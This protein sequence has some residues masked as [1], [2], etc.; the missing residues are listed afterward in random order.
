MLGNAA[1]KGIQKW[2]P[3]REKWY[4]KGTALGGWLCGTQ[5]GASDAE[6]K[7]GKQRNSKEPG[8]TQRITEDRTPTR[9][10]CFRDTKEMSVKILL[11]KCLEE[12]TNISFYGM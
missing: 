3:A 9:D 8:E 4:H 11:F 6:D 1:P 10:P 12:S 7:F 5:V 2:E